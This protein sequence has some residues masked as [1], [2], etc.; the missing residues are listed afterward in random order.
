MQD[1]S[2]KP[3]VFFD[4]DKTLIDDPGYISHPDQVRLLDGAAEAVSRLRAAG[5]TVVVATNQSGVARGLI[6]E[7][8]LKAIH[9]RLRD[10]L[11]A[12]GT[13]LDG[14]YYCPYLDGPEAVREE[15]RRDSDLRKP[16]P[17]MLILAAEELGLD[18]ARSWA[19]GDS[20]RDVQAGLAAGCRTILIGGDRAAGDVEADF[21]AADLLGAAGIILRYAGSSLRRDSVEET[22][23]QDVEYARAAEPAGLADASS[24]PL[25]SPRR[26]PD[27]APP[28][29]PDNPSEAGRLASPAAA[30]NPGSSRS[31]SHPSE[32]RSETAG[33]RNLVAM[34]ETLGRIHEELHMLRRERQYDDFSIAKLVGAVAEAFALCALGWGLYKWMGT[35]PGPDPEGATA[36][37]IWLLAGV[38]FQ[39]LALTCLVASIRK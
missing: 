34:G 25:P 8:D 29:A 30:P 38:V 36:A 33:E 35:G 28:T 20:L 1:I 14:I 16:H 27:A 13:D 19:V 3:A 21:L 26:S 17:G 31:P 7:D 18:L 23:D 10:L 6:S 5:F 4:R 37:T 39:L 11:R 32:P 22:D 15:Y 2:Y 12:E 9:L 24:S